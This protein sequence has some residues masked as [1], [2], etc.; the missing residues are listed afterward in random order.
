M[1]DRGKITN[2]KEKEAEISHREIDSTQVGQSHK[3]CP[4]R[5]HFIAQNCATRLP[6]APKN[7][8]NTF[9]LSSGDSVI[10]CT[11]RREPV[12]KQRVGKGYFSVCF[13]SSCRAAGVDTSVQMKLAGETWVFGMSCRVTVG[14]SG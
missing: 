7:S 1:R 6:R 11:G 9:C 12:G 10:T 3:L 5:R 13:I 4:E 8:V 14:L 2:K